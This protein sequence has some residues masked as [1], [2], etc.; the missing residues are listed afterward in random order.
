MIPLRY[1]LSALIRYFVIAQH[2]LTFI[3]IQIVPNTF[4]EG[5]HFTLIKLI[6]LVVVVNG[7]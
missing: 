3:K 1:Q 6:V 4:G 5:E 7:E 2:G